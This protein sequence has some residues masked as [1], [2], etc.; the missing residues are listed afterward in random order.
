MRASFTCEIYRNFYWD[1]MQNISGLAMCTRCLLPVVDDSAL[2]H[3]DRQTRT[4][5][6]HQ[7]QQQQQPPKETNGSTNLSCNAHLYSAT[8]A[9]T[10][11]VLLLCYASSISYF[12][13][14]YRPCPHFSPVQSNIAGL[15]LIIPHSIQD[16]LPYSFA[17]FCSKD[18]PTKDQQ[19]DTV[20]PQ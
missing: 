19:T 2:Q 14:S 4:G 6:R 18:P 13:L 17:S 11:V 9:T 12:S 8:F 5:T 20:N 1:L 7:K 3:P 15:G 10:R 16:W